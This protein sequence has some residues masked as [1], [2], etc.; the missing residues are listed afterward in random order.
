MNYSLVIYLIL[1]A[2]GL[3]I[4]FLTST[5]QNT[6]YYLGDQI[7]ILHLLFYHFSNFVILIPIWV[8]PFL[9]IYNYLMGKIV[10]SNMSKR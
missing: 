2:L 7:K 9:M 1:S 10:Q 3:L 8:K 4:G 5:Y 6:H